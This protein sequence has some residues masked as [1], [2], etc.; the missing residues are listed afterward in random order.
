MIKIVKIS[1]IAGLGLGLCT[2]QANQMKRYEVKS[3]K[4]EYSLSGGGNVMGVAKIKSVGKK[5]VI[6]DNYG[7]QNLEE[8][9]KVKK[10]T[11]MGETKTTKTHT[12]MYMNDMIVYHVD[13]KHKRI[14]RRAN[15]AGAMAALF[16]GGDTLKESGEA[17]M[18][19]MGGKK[20]GTDKVLGFSC[21][22]WS[23]M[24]SKQCIYKGIPLKVELDVMGMKSIEIAT[25]IEFDLSLNTKDFTL[26]D[27]PIYG[28]DRTPLDKNKLKMMDK[29][30]NAKAKIKAAEGAEAMKGMAA[31]MAAL[32]KAGV[33]LKSSKELTPEQEQIMEKAMMAA[34]GGEGKI[35]AKMKKEILGNEK[36]LSFAQKCFGRANT[37]VEANKCVDKGNEM[38]HD[39]EEH[40]RSWTPVE[41]KK[42]LQEIED[43]KRNIPCIKAAKT[44]QAM[45]QCMPQE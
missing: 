6:F 27:F 11:S 31:G 20:L 26:P 24:G 44:M 10:Q 4:I 37:L 13:F 32:A 33:N 40:Y 29:R 18:K 12:L 21:D 22:V 28:N 1:L 30:D 14:S 38:F 41:K 17:L 43:F 39:D 35:L 25:K 23:I 36:E 16:G 34:M 8:K 2:A 19:Q 45:K 15:S 5:R 3:G 9:V 42:M 7:V